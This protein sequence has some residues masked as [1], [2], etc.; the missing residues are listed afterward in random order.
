[1]SSLPDTQKNITTFITDF[2][3]LFCVLLIVRKQ[4]IILTQATYKEEP[5]H[6]KYCDFPLLHVWL[7]YT[8]DPHI[9]KLTMN[10]C[11]CVSGIVTPIDTI[12][13]KI[14]TCMGST[15]LLIAHAILTLL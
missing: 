9:T 15:I 6:V 11:K 8:V 4:I 7:L 12:N 5:Q 10:A 14:I 2:F 13:H 1:M 3:L